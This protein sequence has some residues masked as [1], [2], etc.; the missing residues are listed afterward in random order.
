MATLQDAS[1]LLELL[2][3]TKASVHTIIKEWAK[4]PPK[5]MG[6]ATLPSRELF[7]AKRTIIAATGKFAEL[8]S[9]PS[10]RLL[11]VSSQYNE[12]RCLH[13]A[14]AM[15]IPDLLAKGGSAGVSIQDISAEVG[16]ES[17]KLGERVPL[18]MA[19]VR[20]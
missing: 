17:R 15:R 16:I 10:D 2:E 6:D 1:Q 11:E 8:V 19:I 12:A 14:A 4:L 7:Q 5:R 20:R 18:A 9:S 3:L 13:I